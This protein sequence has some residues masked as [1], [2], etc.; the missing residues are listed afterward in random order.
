MDPSRIRLED[1]RYGLI[2]LAFRTQN[3]ATYMGRDGNDHVWA[4]GIVVGDEDEIQTVEVDQH[5]AKSSRMLTPGELFEGLEI[6][7]A[8]GRDADIIVGTLTLLGMDL[9]TSSG[10]TAREFADLM[11]AAADDRDW[12]L[13]LQLIGQ[14]REL[15]LS[16]QGREIMRQ[17]A[18][19]IEREGHSRTTLSAAN[20][21]ELS[22]HAL[23][24]IRRRIARKSLQA[25]RMHGRWYVVLD[26][27]A[28]SQ[29]A[30]MN[31]SSVAPVPAAESSPAAPSPFEEATVET[32]SE[33]ATTTRLVDE[34]PFSGHAEVATPRAKFYEESPAESTALE[35]V[36]M[37]E[38]EIEPQEAERGSVEPVSE[39][40][41]DGDLAAFVAQQQEAPEEQE[42]QKFILSEPG[43]TESP[44]D[45][46]IDESLESEFVAEQLAA[47][48]AL[49]KHTEFT[50]EEHAV[51]EEQ[52][53]S[54]SVNVGDQ[55][56]SESVLEQFVVTEPD[57]SVS[58]TKLPEQGEASWTQPISEPDETTFAESP[59]RD[60][61]LEG[62]EIASEETVGE[63]GR[64]VE[65]DE[66]ESTQF[67]KT[68]FDV[69]TGL[70]EPWSAGAPEPQV[71]E[72]AADE[73]GPVEPEVVAETTE[74]VYR[75]AD[76]QAFVSPVS[77]EESESL[78]P[79][80]TH[81]TEGEVELTESLEEEPVASEEVM[82][83]EPT[84]DA[85]SVAPTAREELQSAEDT[86]AET[87]EVSD[88][89]AGE[90]EESGSLAPA[91]T[92]E[93]ERE[94]ELTETLAGEEPSVPETVAAREQIDAPE[95][96]TP[97]DGEE[98]KT[99]EE[100]MA[101]VDTTEESDQYA[102]EADKI[103]EESVISDVQVETVTAEASVLG[104]QKTESFPLEGKQA[105][106]TGFGA[107]EIPTSGPESEPPADEAQP[108]AQPFSEQFAG[109]D[110]A[111]L[112]HL[113]DEVAFLRQQNQEKDRQIVAWI[114]GAHWLQPFV[115]QIRALE[116]QVERLGESQAKRDNE[117]INDLIAER[118]QLRLRL[119]K[120]EHEIESI[121]TTHNEADVKRRSW[122]RRM[123]GSN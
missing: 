35:D 28:R 103:L 77:S 68:T 95:S 50:P 4:I 90:A 24:T 30:E 84:D 75:E 72:L 106:D 92:D 99:A 59:A 67:E 39:G 71:A 117:R 41:T 49:A 17:T 8:P 25:Y 55:F 69:G 64:V 113:R 74:D 14:P 18:V 43:Q 78:A 1:D 11:R 33:L 44:F 120:L 105:E 111:L 48:E 32:E 82:I 12:R 86:A 94:V 52:P 6:L 37:L 101:M 3:R 121:R 93:S 108:T 47:Q 53:L 70:S 91:V 19:E 104:P 22:A 81:D 98:I 80:V 76:E 79:V 122:F 112:S 61:V 97:A 109:A 57:T 10:E 2:G 58:E 56:I 123:M 118:D 60:E 13:P 45:S 20:R 51:E 73:L 115:D 65:A 63:F 29:S 85:E 100:P 34:E 36:D 89:Y 83:S 107:E 66:A 46:A 114:N 54:E 38:T 40:T 110:H 116:Q 7:G 87:A 62:T 42:S 26:N 16:A 9:R 96:A 21:L 27:L 88:R 119:E 15:Q 5:G 23:D 31:G 102:G